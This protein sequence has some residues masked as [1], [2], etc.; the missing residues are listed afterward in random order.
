MGYQITL[1]PVELHIPV[2]RDTTAE[3]DHGGI[4]VR[5]GETVQYEFGITFKHVSVHIVVAAAEQC[6]RCD[7]HRYCEYLLHLYII[8]SILK[9]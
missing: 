8:V 9:T 6:D 2:H 7:H 1:F 5:T 3:V 4:V